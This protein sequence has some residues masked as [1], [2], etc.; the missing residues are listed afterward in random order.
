V[1]PELLGKYLVQN[2][3]GHLEAHLITEVEAYMGE[4]DLACHAS[5]G[6][7]PRTAPMF[8]PPAH[9]YIYLIYGMHEMLNIVTG[10]GHT[11]TAIL[12]RSL[13]TITGPGCLTKQLGIN[14]SLQ[15]LPLGPTTGLW[16]ED[17]HHPP[18]PIHTS[19]RIGVDYAG[20]W[21]SVP[22]RFLLS[23]QNL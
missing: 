22:W 12:I 5:R 4:E 11:P 19:P 13:A 23:N 6:K 15:G 17:R 16:I 10:P 20:P 14:R 3:R 18:L 1:A 8:G 7:T 2:R 21:A 9:L